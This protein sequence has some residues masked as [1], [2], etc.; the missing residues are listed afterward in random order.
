[1]NKMLFIITIILIMVSCT[2][3]ADKK[4]GGNETHNTNQTQN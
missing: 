1:M 4:G 3:E 2:K